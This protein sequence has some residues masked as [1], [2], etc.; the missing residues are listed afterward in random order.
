MN[1]KRFAVGILFVVLGWKASAPAMAQEVAQPSEASVRQPDLLEHPKS[2]DDA[3]ECCHPRCNAC[4]CTYGQ[5]D[6]L[7]MWLDPR[8]ARQPIVVDPNTNTTYL[9]TADLGSNFDPGVQATVGM[10]LCGGRA[11][12]FSYFGLF[13]GNASAVAVSPGSGAFLTFPDNLVGNVFVGMDRVQAN[14]ST[15]LNSFEVNLPC[16]CGCCEECPDQCG[17]GDDRGKCGCANTCCQTFEWYPGFRYLNLNEGLNIAAERTVSG[18]VET[19]SYNLRT[20]NQLFGVQLGA[21]WRRWG[22]RFGWEAGGSAG[23]FGNAAQE[24][25]SVT[26]F[27]DFPLRPTVSNN[28]GQVAFVGG[29]NLSGLYRLNEVWNLRAGYNILLIEGLAMAPDQLDFD[30]ASATGGTQL[31][32]GGGIFLHGINVG[33]EARW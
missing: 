3:L 18:E 13:Q 15:G 24:K 19:G 33:V 23:I 10:R 31:H 7:F 22:S 11:L 30:F 20:T 17:C 16:C 26:D 2:Q 4:P 25:Q 21:R 9:S 27:P 5:V 28:G 14:Y 29:M 12:E 32:D 1:A 6:A 8:F